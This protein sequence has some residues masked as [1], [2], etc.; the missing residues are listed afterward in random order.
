MSVES[1]DA[2]PHPGQVV[3]A[4][5]EINDRC[6]FS[7]ACGSTCYLN[8]V[9]VNRPVLGENLVFDAALSMIQRGDVI[10]HLA[11]VGKEAFESPSL[12]LDIA[13]EYNEASP[14]KRPASLGVIS[15][16]PS[17]IREWLPKFV[18][19]PLSWLAVSVDVPHSGLRA[20]EPF[21][22]LDAALEGRKMGGTHAVAVNS[23]F[24]PDTMND[25]LALSHRMR[26]KKLDQ[27]ALC[28]L[29]LS[30]GGS[31]RSTVSVE[32]LQQMIEKAAAVVD[33]AERVVV[34]TD[35]STL[36]ALLGD[37]GWKNIN[38]NLWRIEVKLPSGLWL[39]ART[40]KPGYFI[41]Q[42]YDGALLSRQDFSRRGVT[43]GRYGQFRSGADINR[44]LREMVIE[45]TA[46]ESAA[47][48]NCA[49][50]PEPIR[51]AVA[52]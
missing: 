9:H 22:A 51:M 43:E 15:A 29:M 13:R 41:R 19:A 6:A 40:P 2:P 11:V 23:T 28:P 8:Q 24:R 48:R 16:S 31:L 45:R 1:L 21:R 10:R 37:N 46:A 42:R 3:L 39:F 12:L 4:N 32:H 38:T 52:A 47:G 20:G 18:G 33:V 34:E 35:P 27:W 49:A 5:L 50:A 30:S 26:G 17:G 36:C 7:V 25:V 44:A 14:T